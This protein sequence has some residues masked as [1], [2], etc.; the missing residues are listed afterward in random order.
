MIS[1]PSLFDC[2][3]IGCFRVSFGNRGGGVCVVQLLSATDL[4]LALRHVHAVTVC[5]LSDWVCLCS[6]G[7]RKL[8]MLGSKLA[9]EKD[10]RFYGGFGKHDSIDNNANDWRRFDVA[11]SKESN[12]N[13]PEARQ[14]QKQKIKHNGCIGFVILSLLQFK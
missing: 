10:G 6:F 4:R 11:D 12:C 1:P 7:R 5:V 2:W 3:A 14:Q 8:Q 13:S 9:V